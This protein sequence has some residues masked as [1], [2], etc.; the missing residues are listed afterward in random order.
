MLAEDEDQDADADAAPEPDP[1]AA[2][3][4]AHDDAHQDH[5]ELEPE[6]QIRHVAPGSPALLRPASSGWLRRRSFRSG[7]SAYS[8]IA[9]RPAVKRGHELVEAERWLVRLVEHL[10]RQVRDVD[11]SAPLAGELVVDHV[12]RSWYMMW[13]QT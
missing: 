1:G 3:A 7:L 9:A 12:Q 10:L 11:E 13:L 8:T 6:P 5:G 4:R 2:G